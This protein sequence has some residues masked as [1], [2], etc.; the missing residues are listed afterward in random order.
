MSTSRNMPRIVG[1]T[2]LAALM[3]A[4]V[5]ATASA[6]RAR[7][8]SAFADDVKAEMARTYRDASTWR[9]HIEERELVADG[10]YRTTRHRVAVGGPNRYRIETIEQDASGREVTSVTLR[11]GN[12]VYAAMPTEDGG[13]HVLEL[14]N[15]P[16][17]LGALADNMLGQRVRDLARAGEMRYAGRDRIRGNAALKLVVE[18]DHLAWVD[19]TTNIPLRE[20]FLADG[21][22]VHEIEFLSFET[23]RRIEEAEFDPSSLGAVP[24]AT[25]DL[26]FRSADL[27]SAPT[28]LGF[29]PREFSAP[30]EWRLL[31]SG[32]VE[33]TAAFDE[34][35]GTHTW[36]SH[37]S[38]PVGPVLITQSA[39]DEEFVLSPE[40]GDGTE[41]PL[42]TEVGG[43]RVAYYTD[44]WRTH[45]TMH[46]GDT[47]VS[48][49]GVLPFETVLDALARVR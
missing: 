24:S 14:R 18:P 29:T 46:V 17:S 7:V 13:V 4:V 16:P 5:V 23:N 37:Y 28:L 15:A 38:T 47:I 30:D 20:Q 1:A 41:G 6:G 9:A 43:H 45:A 27:R 34:V 42:L 33:P 26:G 39:V 10:A 19:A 22:P 35:P 48:V 31:E 8:A 3:I 36:I 12:T 49:E 11:N 2:V 40:A 32:Y 44:P 21:A 25:E